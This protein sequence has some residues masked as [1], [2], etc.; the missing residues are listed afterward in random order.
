MIL[1]TKF[2]FIKRN[3]KLFK[4]GWKILQAGNFDFAEIDVLKCGVFIFGFF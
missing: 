2:I 3:Q 1:V 4:V